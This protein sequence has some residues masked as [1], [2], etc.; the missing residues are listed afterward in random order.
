MLALNNGAGVARPPTPTVSQTPVWRQAPVWR[1][2][3]AMA[4]ALVVSCHRTHAPW[5]QCLYAEATQKEDW[6]VVYRGLSRFIT[7]QILMFLIFYQDSG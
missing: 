3:G 4:A 7:P 6:W 5:R 1:M 2:G